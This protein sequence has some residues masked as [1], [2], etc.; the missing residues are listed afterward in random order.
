MT[1]SLYCDSFDRVDSTEF[2]LE[3]NSATFAP[4]SKNVF[5]MEK[6]IPLVP[7]V[8]IAVFPFNT[9]IPFL[10]Y[11]SVVF[12]KNFEI[13]LWMVTCRA[14]TRSLCSY[15]NVSAVSAFPDLYFA[16]FENSHSLNILQE[17]SISLFMALLNSCNQAEFCCQCLEFLFRSVLC[18]TLIH[19]CPLVMLAFSCCSKVSCSI[20]DAFQFLEPQLCVFLLIICSLQKEFSNLLVSFL[21]SN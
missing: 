17:S 5:T 15:D 12:S 8:T 16:L 11:Q 4:L 21:L 14:D 13:A 20:P 3:P 18:K 2:C 6:P 9:N 7:P 10:Y 19:I 1:L